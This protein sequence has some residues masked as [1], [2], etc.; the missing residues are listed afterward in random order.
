L[1]RQ[2]DP[3]KQLLN[4]RRLVLARSLSQPLERAKFLLWAVVV[5]VDTGLAVE[6][7]VVVLV[8][9]FTQLLL[10]YLQEL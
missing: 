1:T 9:I 7:A 10:T 5:V 6:V 4:G 8:D 2:A 3:A